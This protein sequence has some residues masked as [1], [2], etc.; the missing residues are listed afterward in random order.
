MTCDL[1]SALAS[2]YEQV[3]G[4]RSGEFLVVT[5]LAFVVLQLLQRTGHLFKG[6]MVAVPNHNC[7]MYTRLWCVFEMFVAQ[8]L[9]V[10]VK[11]A[12][13]LASVLSD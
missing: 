5:V 9:L 2:N 11:L 4:G 7:E 6:R 3:L 12:N 10:P 13:T 8:T 1:F